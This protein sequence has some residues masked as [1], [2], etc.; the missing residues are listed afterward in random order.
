[1]FIGIFG[2][3]L[4]G[5]AV[6]VGKSLLWPASI[7]GELSDQLTWTLFISFIEAGIIEETAKAVFYGIVISRFVKDLGV[8]LNAFY[9]F[10]LGLFVG[11][12]FGLMENIYYSYNVTLGASTDS[13]FLNAVGVIFSRNFTSLLAHMIMA[14]TFGFCIAK[15]IHYFKAFLLCVFIHGLYDFFALPS[16]LLGTALGLLLVMVGVCVMIWMGVHT[17]IPKQKNENTHDNLGALEKGLER[18]L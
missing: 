13:N 12:G 15:K 11:M 1:M 18:L 10:S 4:S 3:F 6:L 9:L 7:H 5:I 8:G 16:T 17:Y 14:G 2:G